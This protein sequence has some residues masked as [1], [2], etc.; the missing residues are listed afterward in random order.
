MHQ[1][2]TAESAIQTFKAHFLSILAEVDPNFP[3]NIWDLLLSQAEI[4]LN[5]L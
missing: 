3:K 2:N 4:K 1:C 5:L